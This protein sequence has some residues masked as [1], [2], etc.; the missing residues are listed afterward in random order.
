MLNQNGFKRKRFADIFSEMEVKAKEVYGQQINTTERS[1]LGIL[2]RL[3]AW[4]L[5]RLWQSLEDVY[6]SG[7]IHSATG[8]NLDRLGANYNLARTLAHRAIG[9]VTLTGTPLFSVPL[10]FR[11]QTATN[12]I[13]ETVSIQILDSNGLAKLQV[14]AVE[15]GS[16]GNVGAGTITKIVNPD[17]NVFSVLNVAEASGGLDTESDPV[18][19]SR[20]LTKTQNPGSSGNAAD[21]LNWALNVRGVGKAKVFPLWSG[22][23]TVKV[24]LADTE[25]LPA[26]IELVN[27]ASLYIEKM[28]PIG[29]EV[30]V[31]AARS[32]A[33]NVSVHVTLA[34]GTYL[35]AVTDTFKNDLLVHLKENA[36][37]SSYISIAKIGTLLLGVPGVL[38]YNHMLLNGSD[39]N[40]LLQSDELALMGLLTVEV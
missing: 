8:R 1:A 37:V 25:M 21:Y 2:L 14:R 30:T 11:V 10:G 13:F 24:V 3:V 39:T 33:L 15:T 22:P 12:I 23:G 27:E 28:R 40:V 35:Q 38:D 7:H 32:K 26:S 36:L 29:A 17:A 34:P 16:R 6:Y 31:V 9:E 19:R 5:G 18:F 20:I 4:F